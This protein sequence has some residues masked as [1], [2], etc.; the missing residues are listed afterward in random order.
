MV[1]D[2]FIIYIYIYIYMKSSKIGEDRTP[3]RVSKSNNF[4]LTGDNPIDELQKNPPKKCRKC[5]FYLFFCTFSAKPC[6]V[7]RKMCP[8]VMEMYPKGNLMF[9]NKFLTLFLYQNNFFIL[10]A[11]QNKFCSTKNRKN[12]ISFFHEIFQFFP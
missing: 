9:L 7:G 1:L 4:L 12:Y 10:S 3:I 8:N 6:D 5:G 11:A 2:D